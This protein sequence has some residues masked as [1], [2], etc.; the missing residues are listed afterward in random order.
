MFSFEF[1]LIDVY[2]LLELILLFDIESSPNPSKGG[3]LVLLTFYY[4]YFFEIEL[5]IFFNVNIVIDI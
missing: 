3:E 4:Y 2:F 5:V 1:I